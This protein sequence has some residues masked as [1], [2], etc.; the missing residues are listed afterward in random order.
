MV[1]HF[2]AEE[3]RRRLTLEVCIPVIRQ[4]MIEHSTG[5]TKH[6]LR[7][8]ISLGPE[9]TFAQMPAALTARGYFGAKL[10]SVFADP[11]RPGRRAHRGVVVLFDSR[12]GS[13]AATADAG[14][15]TLV[16][17]AAASAV[18]TD[19]LARKDVRRLAILGTSEQAEAHARALC[20][21]RR[22][23]DIVIWGR[24]ARRSEALSSRLADLEETRIHLSRSAQD[25]AAG[26][27]VVCTLTAATE[28][29]VFGEWIQPGTHV[30]LVGSS[31]PSAREADS[32]LVAKSCYFGDC[33]EHVLAHGAE[34][35]H[36]LADG[37]I[38]EDHFMSEIGDVLSG[39]RKGR[40]GDA[41]ITIYKSLGHAVQDLAAVAY[42]YEARATA[43]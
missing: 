2:E 22:F 19:A 32:G 18:A 34:F 30:N 41:D 27:D 9:Q 1:S 31:G 16:R 13:I 7:S 25:A 40:R 42:L 36:A 26:A 10:V 11:A 6:L 24:D 38:K 29:I 43:R 5:D 17:T 21:V 4:A 3:V 12:D 37:L 39:R 14:A 20:L 23:T 15:V 28:P 33:R 35:R 8:F